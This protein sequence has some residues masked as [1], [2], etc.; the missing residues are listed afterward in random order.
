MASRFYAPTGL[1]GAAEAIQAEMQRRADDELKRRQLEMQ[2]RAQTANEAI[3]RRELAIREATAKREE[4]EAARKKAGETYRIGDKRA[5]TD[6]TSP[7]DMFDPTLAA[8]H[9]K[10][11]L[12]LPGPQASAS[13]EP[14]GVI[15]SPPTPDQADQFGATPGVID[16]P[17][18]G[19]PEPP[20]MPGVME[21]PTPAGP[22]P[23]F[24]QPQFEHQA[25]AQ[26]FRGTDTQRKNE[27]AR[28]AVER[29]LQEQP[30]LIEKNPELETILR[31]AG[32]TE[33][34]AGVLPA[35]AS[36]TKEGVARNAK[37]MTYQQVFNAEQR[38]ADQW[39][40][41]TASQRTTEQQL[42]LMDVALENRDKAPGAAA[43]AIR[44]FWEK[45]LD[46]P[47][48]VR[49]GE[50]ARQGEGLSLME[51]LRG[52][53]KAIAEG[54]GKIPPE[55][56]AEFVKL[57]HA[58]QERMAAYNAGER[59]RI[60]KTSDDMGFDKSHIF[61]DSPAAAPGPGPAPGPAPGPGPAPTPTPTPTTPAAAPKITAHVPRAAAE[62]EAKKRGITL[63][64]FR[65]ILMQRGADIAP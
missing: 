13:L 49:E 45:Y 16:A 34:W 1:Q 26:T 22:Q 9:M 60:E 5:A 63:D 33:N 23:P 18:Y 15:A 62:A 3:Q 7:A 56:L 39:R 20:P 48:V 65:Q 21:M 55:Q 27:Q 10:P 17:G 41:N 40:R 61:F 14:G 59:I 19:A 2:E 6:T 58:F 11:G 52:M 36:A 4:E 35:I 44:V 28:M 8:T 42:A 57:A 54:G 25:A 46:P 38:L 51:R 64:A 53:G 24:A 30:D 29:I 37:G 12:G 47:S 43:E 32:A 50:Y 31:V